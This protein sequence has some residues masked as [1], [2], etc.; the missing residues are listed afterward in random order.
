MRG[1][2]AEFLVIGLCGARSHW[3]QLQCYRDL[4]WVHLQ[5][6]W[7]WSTRH[8]QTF[9]NKFLDQF[10]LLR[11]PHPP[12]PT[13]WSFLINCCYASKNI[14]PDQNSLTW[15]CKKFVFKLSFSL[16][17][18]RVT[19]YWITL[20]KKLCCLSLLFHHPRQLGKKVTRA[21]TTQ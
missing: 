7:T 17:I 20:Q 14:D 2:W 19:S 18:L 16:N 12:L 1:S 8:G 6:S 5:M 11:C 10:D 3:V 21:L 15:K 13:C 9:F 4:M